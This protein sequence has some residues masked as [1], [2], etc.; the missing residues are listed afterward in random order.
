MGIIII[1]FS[2]LA[3]RQP[4]IRKETVRQ[5]VSKGKFGPGALILCLI[6]KKDKT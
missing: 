6:Y 5:G 1:W 2:G 4:Q 3:G